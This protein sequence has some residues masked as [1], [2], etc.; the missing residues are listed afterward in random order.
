MN[1]TTTS[2]QPLT[3]GGLLQIFL[4]LSLSDMI[5]IVAVPLI[6]AVLSR[7][8]DVRIHLAAYGAAQ[9]LAL[10][11]ESPII[12]ILHAST[13]AA[14]SP[15]AYRTL[16]RL[17]WLLNGLLT[18]LYALAAFTPAY[19]W[20]ANVALGLP[21]EVAAAARPA[22]AA[23]LLWPA[24]IGVR[25]YLQGKLIHHRRSRDIMLAGFVR[26]GTL[27]SVMLLAAWAGL[28]GALVA[29]LGL[30]ASVIGEALATAFFY[31][32][33]TRQLAATAGPA[34]ERSVETVPSR[35]LPLLW[36][37]LPLAL[38]Q[39][40]VWLVRPATTAGIARAHLATLA[41]AAWPVAWSVS[42]L[43]GNGTRMIQQL[44]ISLVKD[45][46]SARLLRRFTWLVGFAF[47]VA[48][49]LIA[50]TPLADFFLRTALGLPPELVGISRPVLA[51]TAF[52]P[53]E[54]ALFNW[55]QGLMVQT[56]RTGLVNA[57]AF[58]GGVVTVALIFAGALL[59]QWPGTLLAAV[60]SMIGMAL[61]AACLWLIL[62]QAGQRWLLGAGA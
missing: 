25:R 59:T 31:R 45:A 24:A 32:R 46:A 26:L 4:P 5:M 17:T 6:S 19:T 2:K 37:Y 7:L 56:G 38:T 12:M 50:F 42:N 49:A 41:L 20:V 10:V 43:L 23:L 30:V 21:P 52:Y 53:V 47:S 34:N 62:R 55:L 18:L 33:L 54:V 8:P 36:W 14:S 9:N 61:E 29:G 44:T 51:I 13:L 60:A 27:L 40:L 16:G 39:L 57:A 28:P 1:N 11:L 48:L 22:F 15:Q 35:L 58:V 3:I